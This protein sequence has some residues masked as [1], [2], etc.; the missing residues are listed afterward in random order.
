MCSV[1]SDWLRVD[2]AFNTMKEVADHINEVKRDQDDRQ[3]IQASLL[4]Y[5]G[6]DLCSLGEF[7][8]DGE[9]F[10]GG[11]NAR[12]IFLFHKLFL[13]TKIHHDRHHEVKLKIS[14]DNLIVQEGAEN[15]RN[16]SVTKFDDKNKVR[17]LSIY[18]VQTYIQWEETQTKMVC[19]LRRCFKSL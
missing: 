12:Y 3:H 4:N 7:V 8:K 17:K 18:H 19:R 1:S 10:Q 6:P 11:K 13:L 15:E 14:T 2:V 5:D 16:F 9:V